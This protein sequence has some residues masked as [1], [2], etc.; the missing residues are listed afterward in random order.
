M[1]EIQSDKTRRFCHNK[2]SKSSDE[3][4]LSVNKTFFSSDELFYSVNKPGY[5]ADKLRYS[6]DR[7]EYSS[8]KLF[9]SVDKAFFST[10]KAIFSTDKLVSSQP[11]YDFRFTIHEYRPVFTGLSRVLIRNCPFSLFVVRCSVILPVSVRSML[12]NFSYT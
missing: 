12:K 4:D 5:S 10:D 11:I 7:S 1:R 3:R 9:C 8:D 6:I 2:F